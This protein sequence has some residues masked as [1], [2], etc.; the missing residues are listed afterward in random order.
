MHQDDVIKKW[1]GGKR[2]GGSE[3]HQHNKVIWKEPFCCRDRQKLSAEVGDQ[4]G[5]E[6]ECEKWG[7]SNRIVS[8]S[9]DTGGGENR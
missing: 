2:P 3:E 1:P 7:A 8:P 4:Q 5:R 6:C 9:E